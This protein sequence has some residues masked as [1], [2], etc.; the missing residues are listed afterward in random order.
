MEIP[1]EMPPLPLEKEFQVTSVRQRLK[2]LSREELEM[3]LGESLDLVTRLAHQL[4]ELRDYI[5]GKNNNSI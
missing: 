5:E 4:R 1:F 3:L 2:E